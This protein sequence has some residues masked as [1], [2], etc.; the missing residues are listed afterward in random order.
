MDRRY[1]D[2]NDRTR[3]GLDYDRYQRSDRN[4]DTYYNAR[5]LE[6]Q[7]ERD[8]QREQGDWNSREQGD[9]NSDDRYRNQYM[10]RGDNRGSAYGRY[11]EEDRDDGYRGD[12][13]WDDNRKRTWSY[14]GIYD[15]DRDQ[16]MDYG[17]GDNTRGNVGRYD[18]DR[19]RNT[20]YGSRWQGYGTSSN[21]YNDYDRYADRGTGERQD[22]Y[23]GSRGGYNG[24][25]YAYQNYGNS[26]NFSDRYGSP[27]DSRYGSGFGNRNDDR[28]TD[29]D[30]DRYWS[31]RY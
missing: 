12:Y 7:F 17:Y 2:L 16:S 27:D 14:T 25:G 26:A 21:Y 29:D 15:R 6:D 22:F 11:R 8:Y 20:D 3:P 19:D 31:D 18:T 28:M 9:W 4:D 13:Q 5:H 30:R 1:R 24:S 10:N 23:P